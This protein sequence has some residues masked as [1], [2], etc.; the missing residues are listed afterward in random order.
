ME[1]DAADVLLRAELLRAVHLF[2]LDLQL[3][4]SPLPQ[5]DDVASTEMTADNLGE[6]PFGSPPETPAGKEILVPAN[7]AF[8]TRTPTENRTRN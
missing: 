8:R 5:L 2:A 7:P 3:Q 4:T 6:P 1:A